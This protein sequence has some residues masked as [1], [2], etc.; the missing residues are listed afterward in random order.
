MSESRRVRVARMV[1]ETEKQMEE[2][3]RKR[4][5]K[6]VSSEGAVN[7]SGG[8]CET[9]TPVKSATSRLTAA[10]A[11]RARRRAVEVGEREG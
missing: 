10:V 9:R 6:Q 1:R 3:A 2:K 8:T 4:K 7:P 5:Q 11:A